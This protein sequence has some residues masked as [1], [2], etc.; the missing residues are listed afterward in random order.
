MEQQ[1]PPSPFTVALR[2]G[3]VSNLPTVW[4]NAAAAICLAGGGSL[5]LFLVCAAAMSLLYVGGMF[6]NDAFDAP[7]DA[8]HRPERPIPAGHVSPRTVVQAGFGMLAAGVA[9]TACTGAAAG[10]SALAL[11]VLIVVYN[12]K[13]KG[14][15]YSPLLMGLCRVFVYVSCALATGHGLSRPVFAGAALLLCYLIGLSG[16]AKQEL[17]P[18]LGR[19]WPLMF[20]GPPLGAGF[21]M[22]ALASATALLVFVSHTVYRLCGPRP[23]LTVGAG[24]GRLIAGLCLLDAVQLAS[25]GDHRAAVASAAATLLTL[26]L[27]R[28]VAG[29]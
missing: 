7:W 21:F 6:L 26:G 19:L 18:Q 11:A 12:A 4:T 14:N 23:R 20:L 27:Q 8:R 9:L 16:V 15:P 13:H 2:L 29:T 24:V 3:R 1:R 10:L 17:E 5:G 25:R 22:G 28:L